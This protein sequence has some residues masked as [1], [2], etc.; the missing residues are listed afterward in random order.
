MAALAV[1]RSDL[2]EARRKSAEREAAA[3]MLVTSAGVSSIESTKITSTAGVAA[4]ANQPARREPCASRPP[5]P[6]ARE[7][8]LPGDRLLSCCCLA[9]EDFFINLMLHNDC[10]I[11]ISLHLTEVAF[12]SFPFGGFLIAS[13]GK[14]IYPK[15]HKHCPMYIRGCQIGMHSRL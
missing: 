1:A 15:L 2:D 13:T 14:V 8:S 12:A 3:T 11:K 5:R 9:L 6:L 10:F 4:T 7:V